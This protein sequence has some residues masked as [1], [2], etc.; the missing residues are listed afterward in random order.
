MTRDLEMLVTVRRTELLDAAT[1]TLQTVRTGFPKGRLVVFGNDLDAYTADIVERR[2]SQAGGEFHNLTRQ[3][4]DLWLLWR[5]ESSTA[6]ELVILDGDLVFHRTMACSDTS[7][8]R[9]LVLTGPH[10]P[11]HRNPI[12]GAWHQPRI[13]TCFWWCRP[14]AL[15]RRLSDYRAALPRVPWPMPW[16]PTAQAWIPGDPPAFHDTGAQLCRVV[17]AR[18]FDAGALTAFTHLHCGTW[19][20]VAAAHLP[21]LPALHAAAAAGRLTETDYA[22]IRRQQAQWYAAHAA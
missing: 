6:D 7:L 4:H 22:G 11:L 8:S 3:R 20:D 1:L 16:H 18:A 5:L 19:S 2:A 14:T 10:E 13:H 17:G 12:T 9:D 21:D 15:R